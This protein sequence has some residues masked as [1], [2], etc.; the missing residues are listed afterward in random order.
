[1][2][3]CAK[4]SPRVGL[5]QRRHLWAKSTNVAMAC[6][7]CSLVKLTHGKA[8]HSSERS[9]YGFYPRTT[10]K[11]N[12]PWHHP[13]QIYRGKMNRLEEIRG[14][15]MSFFCPFLTCSR[16]LRSSRTPNQRVLEREFF[17]SVGSND[18]ATFSNGQSAVENHWKFQIRDFCTE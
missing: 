13:S 10:Y 14:P 15:V 11:V 2:P 9:P 3:S 4:S 6:A 5:E 12:T 8:E 16:L 7:I 1:M 18:I 17:M